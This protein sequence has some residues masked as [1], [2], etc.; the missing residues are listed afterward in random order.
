MKYQIQEKVKVRRGVG[1]KMWNLMA[2]LPL[3]M[4]APLVRRLFAIDNDLPKDLVFKVAE[5]YEEIEQAF[6]VAFEAFHER[7]LVTETEN[8]LRVTKFHALPTTSI[9]IAKKGEEV[10]ATLTVVMDSALGLPLEKLFNIQDVKRKSLRVAEISTLAI[11]RNF[12]SQR[13]QLL[14]PLC[15]FMYRFCREYLGVDTLVAAVHPE[16]QDFYRCVLL[17]NDI[18]GGE[19]K[20]YEFVQGAAAVAS[21][22][23]ISDLPKNYIKVY[24]KK[25][26]KRNLYQFFVHQPFSQFQ[27]PEKKPYSCSDVSFSPSLLEYF[28]RHKSEVMEELTNREKEIISTSYFYP[29]YRS[30]IVGDADTKPLFP[31]EQ[32][33]FTVFC[34]V[35]YHFENSRRI[36]SGHALEASRQGLKIAA[37]KFPEASEGQGIVLSLELEDG[38]TLLLGG[39]VT[40]LS[41][42]AG[43]FG[44]RLNTFVPKAWQEHIRGFENEV[45]MKIQSEQARTSR[46]FR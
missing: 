7:G 15:N 11:K 44:V 19:V 39:H 12:R 3:W 31:R 40:W 42:E 24:G 6:R 17:F 4:R 9:L 22:L 30:V 10:I 5:T 13:G 28:F 46:R 43:H 32:A 34:K 23:R 8:R 45:L 2:K 36:Y 27:F 37:E 20:T 21:W 41:A 25:P 33:R 29:E 16:V 38:S 18:E 35:R 26:P 1:R 14:L